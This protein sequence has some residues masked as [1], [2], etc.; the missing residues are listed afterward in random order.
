MSVL[1]E[2]FEGKID[3][4]G[5]RLVDQISKVVL[6]AAAIISFIVGFAMQSLQITFFLYGACIVVLALVVI[7]PWPMFNSHPVKWLSVSEEE[8]KTK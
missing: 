8:K 4:H 3:F 6:V 7:P 5:Q 1:S 2:M